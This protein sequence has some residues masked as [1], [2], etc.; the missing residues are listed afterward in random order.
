MPLYPLP[1]LVA[2][3]GFLFILFS[4]PNFLHEMR[5][6]GVILLAGAVVYGVRLWRGGHDQ[7]YPLPPSL[8]AKSSK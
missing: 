2:L 5:T 3:S 6:A 8:D 1:V 7:R 4:R